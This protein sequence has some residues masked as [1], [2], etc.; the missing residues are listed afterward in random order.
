MEHPIALKNNRKKFWRVS[1]SQRSQLL[2]VI[3]TGSSTG[4]RPVTTG[5]R[6][7]S[8]L[9]DPTVWI[10]NRRDMSWKLP[11][12]ADSFVMQTADAVHEAVLVEAGVR[13]LRVVG[14]RDSHTD[15]GREV[16]L[17]SLGAPGTL[18]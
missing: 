10:S 12:D 14:R 15:V 5:P 6:T 17:E 13:A 8:L 2:V 11:L 3:P 18:P 16:S 4:W 7:T 9:S 1:S